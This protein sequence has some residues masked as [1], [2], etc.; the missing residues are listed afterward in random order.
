MLVRLIF[1]VYVKHPL[2][3]ARLMSCKFLLDEIIRLSSEVM[4]F[5]STRIK[6][7]LANCPLI[8]AEW[9]D[10]PIDFKHSQGG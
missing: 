10:E 6:S 9:L 2:R 1:L 4:Q 8:C 3:S 5:A 7:S